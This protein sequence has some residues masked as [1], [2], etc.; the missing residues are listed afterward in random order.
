MQLTDTHCHLD[1]HKFDEDRAAVIERAEKTGLVRILIPALS[2]TSSLS[3]IKLAESHPMLYTAIGVHPTETSDFRLETLGELRKL[4]SHPKV[5]A[6][7]EIGLDYY[8]DSAPHEMQKRALREQL[9]LATELDLPVVI[10]LREKG[11]AD[12]GPCA[13]DA[14]RILED[15]VTGLG[16]GKEAL[17]ANPGVL[18]SF[19]GSLETAQR[20][21]SLNFCIGITG[22]VTFKNARQKQEMVAQLPLE[23]LLIETDAPYLA[24]HPHR[25]KR[26]EPAFVYEIAD[27]IA[28]LQSRDLEEVAAMTTN[29]AA[30]LFSWGEVVF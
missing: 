8:W 16:S 3:T 30:Q 21:I 2:V 9:D 28:Q 22:P 5:E 29:N 14:M 12:H 27:K 15:W 19:S 25:G 23:R 24:P 1:L 7:G 20:A 11:D 13:E 17:K 4:L 18:H 6:I 26:N 10:H